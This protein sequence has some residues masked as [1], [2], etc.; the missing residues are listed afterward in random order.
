MSRDIDF[1]LF[2]G[3]I[4]TYLAVMRI[5]AIAS[6]AGVRVRWRPFNLRAL[7]MEQNNISFARNPV[8]MS[9]CWRDVQRRA[10]EHQLEFVPRP[11]YPV[12]LELLALRV[13]IVASLDGW[14][15]QYSRATYTSWFL[16]HKQAGNPRHVEELLKELG[17]PVAEVLA[18]SRSEEIA[19]KLR[20]ETDAAR[21]LGVFGSPTFAVG[22]ELFWGDDRL[23]QA[24]AW[25]QAQGE[26][27]DQNI[28]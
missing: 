22:S 15:P 25:A 19:G 18:R 12:D 1:F 23:E 10:A 3:S 14:C 27:M 28:H 4:Y 2:Y 11:P 6:S 9:Y 17:R 8:R 16:R 21:R 5:E 7:L 24:V 20:S 26:Q 13:G